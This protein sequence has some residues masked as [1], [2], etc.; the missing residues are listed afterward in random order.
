GGR[1]AAGGGGV[2][3]GGGR[4]ATRPGSERRDRPDPSAVGGPVPRGLPVC[5]SAQRTSG[6]CRG[7]NLGAPCALRL[8]VVG[9][10]VGW[11]GG[12]ATVAL[13]LVVVGSG[14]GWPGGG[15]QP[16]MHRRGH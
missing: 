10:G 11:P 8:A 3:A 16:P 12:A 4:G 9:S 14:V 7:R 2:G 6:R 5:V 1:G 15:P 13:R